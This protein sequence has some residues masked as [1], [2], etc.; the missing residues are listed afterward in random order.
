MNK[1]L[2]TINIDK[3]VKNP[4]YKKRP[5][6]KKGVQCQERIICNIKDNTK[7]IFL[8]KINEDTTEVTKIDIKHNAKFDGSMGVTVSN[9]NEIFTFG[10]YDNRTYVYK[11]DI[12]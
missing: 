5:D 11:K 10:G 4:R 8:W 1:L 2:G 6:G 3:A 12:R 7:Q 9:S